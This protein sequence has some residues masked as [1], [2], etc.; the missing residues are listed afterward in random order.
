MIFPDGFTGFGDGRNLL[1]AIDLR[2]FKSVCHA[3]ARILGGKVISFEFA[4]V[5]PNF[6]R[7]LIEWGYESKRV[8]VLCN[9]AHYLVAF[10]EPKL[11]HTCVN[12]YV[13]APVLAAAFS[14]VSDWKIFSKAQL[15]TVVD[16]EMVQSMSE[17]DRKTIERSRRKGW[18]GPTR[19]VGDFFFHCSD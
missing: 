19:T 1:P 5:T 4:E 12:E 16:E 7:A 10:C 17:S 18:F 11:P 8:S 9:R 14:Q 13:D 6:H 3:A 15:E 2:V